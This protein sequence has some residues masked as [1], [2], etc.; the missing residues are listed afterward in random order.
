[1]KTKHTLV[2]N[3]N[4]MPIGVLDSRTAFKNVYSESVD[5]IES[6][7]GE[8]FTSPGAKWPVPSIVRTKR[9]VNLPY[10]KAV[11]TKR[12]VFKRDNYTCVYCGEI[13]TDKSLTWDH[14]LPKSRKGKNTWENLAT[15]CF[16]CNNEKDNMT[17]EEIGW[18][19]PVAFHPHYLVTLKS[20]V[21]ETPSGWGPY[22]MV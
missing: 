21:R 11:L 19:A 12:N 4:F 13:G 1:M 20:F 7:E 17:P 15:A 9:Y 3:N 22:L 18:V 5:L 16:K 14:I 10:R 2:L 6:Y 8:F